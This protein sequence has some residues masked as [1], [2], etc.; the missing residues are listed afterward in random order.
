MAPT[1][2]DAR[3][4][5]VDRFAGL[6]AGADPALD[7]A[8]LEIAAAADPATDPRPAAL[9]AL[10]RLAVGVD[11]V[12]GLIRRLYVEEGFAGDGER[13]HDP[14]NSSLAQVLRRR[15]GIPITLAVVAVEVGRR[16]GLT[17]EP[18][19]MPGHFLARPAGAEELLDPFT[20][21]RVD[22]AGCAALFRAATGAAPDA[23]SPALLA[24]T[25]GHGVLTR[26]L[27]N[28]R[29]VHRAAGSLPDLSWVLEM[30]L[31]LP[32]VS[33]AE[34]AELAEVRGR[35]AEYRAAADLLDEWAERLPETEALRRRARTWRAR[36]N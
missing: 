36:L 7:V 19:G 22:V 16:A 27:T 14:R 23:F 6:V 26:I 31:A 1:P 4:A 5:A 10:D 21:R 3:A 32:G 8:A 13:Y 24:T 18:V 11:G 9:A 34:V 29:V 30:R 15:R 25:D 2:D 33:A 12:D 35:R 17:I 28:L 20:G